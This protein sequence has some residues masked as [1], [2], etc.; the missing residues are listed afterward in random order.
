MTFEAADTGR[1]SNRSQFFAALTF[2]QHGSA[3][4]THKELVFTFF[5]LSMLSD[6]LN[7]VHET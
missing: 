2:A 6:H 5:L 7:Q 3:S 1:I 4:W